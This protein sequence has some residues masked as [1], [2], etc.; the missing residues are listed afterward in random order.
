MP[1]VFL[2]LRRDGDQYVGT[3]WQEDDRQ[4]RRG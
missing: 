3:C 2:E 4:G 1:V